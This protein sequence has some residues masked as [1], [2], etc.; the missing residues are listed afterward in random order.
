MRFF[1]LLA[2]CFAAIAAVSSNPQRIVGGSVTTIDSY[3]TLAGLLYSFDFNT[4]WQACVGA[5]LNNRAILTAASCTD[6]YP[7]N[8]WRIRVGSTWANSGGIVHNLAANIIHP[9][10]NYTNNDNDVAIIRSATTFTFN[11]NV[12]AASIA[13]PNYNLLDNQ[14]VWV[15]GWGTTYDGGFASDQL[16]HVQLV[17]INQ[18]T[19]RSNYAASSRR[20][21]VTDNMLCSGWPAG[22]RGQCLGDEGSPLYHNGVVV[23]LYSFGIGCGQDLYPAVN[24]RVS[25]YTAWISSNA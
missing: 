3:P 9:S 22:G 20:Y 4:Y 2:L 5:I 13:G 24:T 1:A 17:T 25:R 6:G 10:Y 7:N 11:N 15:A 14:A 16:R 18:N 12:R 21:A 8:R 19:C 23:G